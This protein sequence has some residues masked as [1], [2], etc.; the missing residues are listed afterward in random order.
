MMDDMDH[1]TAEHIMLLR[2]K[3]AAESAFNVAGREDFD[4]ANAFLTY[5]LARLTAFY[6]RQRGET[7][8]VPR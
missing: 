3:E 8:D 7:R 6:R 5:A 4:T 1:I 2:Q